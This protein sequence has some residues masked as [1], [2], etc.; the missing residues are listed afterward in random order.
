MVDSQQ[1]I[2][3]PSEWATAQQEVAGI[4][5]GSFDA[6]M[7][8]PSQIAQLTSLQDDVDGE[9]HALSS[10]SYGASTDQEQLQRAVDQALVAQIGPQLT[11]LREHDS[12]VQSRVE[13]AAGNEVLRKALLDLQS[14]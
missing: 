13:W 5:N 7:F 6:D 4:F 10:S 14:R 1:H 8:S 9:Q 12:G 11:L 2:W 3:T